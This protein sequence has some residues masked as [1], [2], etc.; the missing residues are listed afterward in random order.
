MGDRVAGEAREGKS[1]QN[2][3]TAL[4][5]LSRDVHNLP[6]GCFKI[7]SNFIHLLQIINDM[8]QIKNF[9]YILFFKICY[10]A[11]LFYKR[12]EVLHV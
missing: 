3:Q 11:V 7:V 12:P 4:V 6:G 9:K 5:M 10:R 2:H 8:P 1:T